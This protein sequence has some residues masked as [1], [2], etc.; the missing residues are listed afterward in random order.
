MPMLSSKGDSYLFTPSGNLKRIL[1]GDLKRIRNGQ[2][3]EFFIGASI[4]EDV[5][6]LKPLRKTCLHTAPEICCKG[7]CIFL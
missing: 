3:Q 7:L 4:T 6:M 2:F 1:M 5:D